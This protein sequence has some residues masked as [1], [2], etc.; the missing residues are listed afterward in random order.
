MDL[1]ALLKRVEEVVA[2]V[3]SHL[4]Y[5][6]IERELSMD[7]GRWVLRL[8]IDKAGG[9]TLDDCERASRGVEDIIEVEG[10]IPHAYCLEVSSPGI[11]RPIRRR[12]DFERFCGACIR[13]KTHAPVDGRSNFKGTLERF[14][15]DEI[16][17]E[18]D[19]QHFR[20][21]YAAM[22]KAKLVEEPAPPK[23]KAN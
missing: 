15:G 5:D 2:P 23:E 21:P 14:E 3:L 10:L 11:P 17:M 13:L 20:I 22:A 4:G 1:Q 16:V 19:G 18:V 7:S 9:V 8:F 6:L 12:E